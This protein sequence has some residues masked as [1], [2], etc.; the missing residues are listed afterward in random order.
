[1]E[2]P[3]TRDRGDWI[4]WY[5]ED[6]PG[7]LALSLAARGLAEGIARKMGRK[8]SELPLGSRG[9]R[10]IEQLMGRPWAEIEP[11]IRELLAKG[12]ATEEFIE[13]T[14]ARLVYDATRRVLID[15]DHETRRLG[16]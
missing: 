9:I 7:W 13:G 8:R 12:P 11:A 14:P 4:P 5:V 16:S 10:G 1:M 2:R 15:P 3:V 6:S